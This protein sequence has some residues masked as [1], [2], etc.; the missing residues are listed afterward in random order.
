M[1]PTAVFQDLA[2][3]ADAEGRHEVMLSAGE[4]MHDAVA[5]AQDRRM[6]IQARESHARAVDRDRVALGADVQQAKAEPLAHEDRRDPRRE[7]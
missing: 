7:P 4:D 1:K 6:G 5:V 2:V 3:G